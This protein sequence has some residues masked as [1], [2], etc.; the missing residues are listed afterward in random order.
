MVRLAVAFVL[1]L[2]PAARA[3]SLSDIHDEIRVPGLDERR[4]DQEAFFEA[5]EPVLSRD[6][7][8][9]EVLG[10]SAEGRSIRMISFGHGP[11]PVL[12]W[13]QMHGDE[14]T[15]TM[16]LADIYAFITERPEHPVARAI[17]A[18]A[19][20]HTIPML[21]PDGAQRF[22][23]RNAQGIDVN[24][25]ARNLS[26]PE[27]RLL[28]AAIDRLKPRFGFNLH[29]QNV[30]TRAGDTERRAAIALL[31]PPFNT[32]RDVNAVRDRAMKVAS[33]FRSAVEP[34]VGGHIARYDDSFNPRAFGD[35]TTKWGVSTVLV[36][37]GGWE[38]DP[39]K[40]Y[41][42]KVNFVGLL[43]A[44]Q[45]IADGSYGKASTRGYRELPENSSGIPDLLIT[46]GTLVVQ[47]LPPFR[48]DLL[49]NYEDPLRE[50]DAE[51]VDIGDLVDSESQD[52]LSLEG[53]YLIF[54]DEDLDRN[55]D[56]AQIAP[57]RP[58]KFA[59]S[60]TADGKHLLW[61]FDGTGA[62]IVR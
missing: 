36:E 28:K 23:R 20:V 4:F 13:S 49:I 51:I 44:L 33:V 6:A 9:T 59:V 24:R 2:A 11:T 43:T 53:R 42:R 41:V 7:L 16:A 39:Q 55:D 45:A 3:Q 30:R 52:T 31:S 62:S 34:F 10:Q 57:G 61:R 18:G 25:D 48:A 56:G 14:S 29:D 54:S 32:A 50:E 15:A 17:L 5:V 46:G 35:L 58:A 47:G 27:G 22:Q 19:T 8:K 37:S 60:T 1:L 40:Q 21:N 38:G 26:T 12:L